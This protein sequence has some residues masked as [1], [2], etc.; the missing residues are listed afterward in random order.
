MWEGQRH[1]NL[2]VYVKLNSIGTAL[3]F[4][5]IQNRKAFS[6]F[7]AKT[8][9]SSVRYVL[10][11]EWSSFIVI[12]KVLLLTFFECVIVIVAL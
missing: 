1:V 4:T 6:L 10:I 7:S 12:V 11:M 5:D 9:I 2:D 3:V 8:D